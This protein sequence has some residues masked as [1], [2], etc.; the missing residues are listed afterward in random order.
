MTEKPTDKDFWENSPERTN[1]YALF[2]RNVDDTGR[3][4]FGDRFIHSQEFA[5]ARR[6][7]RKRING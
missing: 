6:A 5:N 7:Y 4:I 3:R 1:A 2:L